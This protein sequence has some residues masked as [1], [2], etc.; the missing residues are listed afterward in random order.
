[1]LLVNS[2]DALSVGLMQTALGEFLF[3]DEMNGGRMLGIEVIKSLNVTKGQAI[4]VDAA[5]LAT[6]FDGTEFDVSD[7]ATVVE[8][9]ADGTAPTHAT[10]AAGAVGTAG[11]VPRDGGIPVSGGSGAAAAGATARSLWQTWSVGV[12]AIQPVSWGFMQPGAT[13]H[14]SAL[15]W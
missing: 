2:Q 12:R 6:A 5:A 10:G 15:T 11:Q 4:V 14:L 1:V 13:V 8:A 3:R 7:V 9:D